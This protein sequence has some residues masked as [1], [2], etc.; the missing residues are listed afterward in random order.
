[1]AYGSTLLFT[2]ALGQ[3]TLIILAGTFTGVI[4]SFLQSRGSRV[5]LGLQKAA[6]GLLFLAGVYMVFQGVKML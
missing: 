1:M 6:G 2:Y 4:E 5:S 3:G